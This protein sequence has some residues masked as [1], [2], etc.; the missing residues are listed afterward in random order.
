MSDASNNQPAPTVLPSTV[1]LCGLACHAN[2]AMATIACT[3]W[4]RQV[5]LAKLEAEI[6]RLLFSPLLPG[7]R[8]SPIGEYY[9][10][11]QANS[12]K[13]IGY[14]RYM[15]DLARESGWQL[16]G[17]NSKSNIRP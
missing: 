13:L 3:I 10:Q 12:D 17:V 4:E 6:T 16:L 5:E 8:P 1:D 15:N 14:V 11:M 7:A 9:A 2:R